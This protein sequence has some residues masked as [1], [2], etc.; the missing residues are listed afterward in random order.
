MRFLRWMISGSRRLTVYRKG[1]YEK[2]FVREGLRSLLFV[3][4]VF[5]IGLLLDMAAHMITG[6]FGLVRLTAAWV[7]V[8][9]LLAGGLGA[10]AVL[11]CRREDL[12]FMK[13]AT[14]L[15]FGVM[16]MGVLFFAF[17]EARISG[18]LYIYSIAVI[19]VGTMMNFPLRETAA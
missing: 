4:L 10:A 9:A 15:I 11:R 6:N 5:G 8:G 1:P 18:G 14:R 13:K 7:L 12:A 2:M 19:V 16:Y 17:W 3:G